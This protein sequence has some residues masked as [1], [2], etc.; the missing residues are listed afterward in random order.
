[1]SLNV[2]EQD[3]STSVEKSQKTNGLSNN[4][5]T[6]S[7]FPYNKQVVINMNG[8]RDNLL[9]VNT[10]MYFQKIPTISPQEIRKK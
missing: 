1:V 2:S 6:I 7:S 10:P 3:S 4:E 9:M 8:D 5:Y